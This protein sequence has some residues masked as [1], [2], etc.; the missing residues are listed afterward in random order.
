MAFDE[1][2]F[3]HHLAHPNKSIQQVPKQEANTRHGCTQCRH[4]EES[5]F[6]TFVFCHRIIIVEY[7][8]NKQCRSNGD[9]ERKKYI[10]KQK[11]R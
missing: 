9:A 1:C 10:G 8:N 3:I 7:R 4:F 6:E 2:E 11:K 5:M